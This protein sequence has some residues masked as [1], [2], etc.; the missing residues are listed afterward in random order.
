MMA[1]LCCVNVSWAYLNDKD[2]D[3]N[4][5]KEQLQEKIRLHQ[6][7]EKQVILENSDTPNQ[8]FVSLSNNE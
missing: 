1:C 3:S 6:E 4:L 8:N 7:P 2:L 5:T